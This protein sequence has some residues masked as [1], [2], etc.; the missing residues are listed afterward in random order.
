MNPKM[1]V[2]NANIPALIKGEDL[3]KLKPKG[4]GIDYCGVYAFCPSCS[5]YVMTECNPQNDC[6]C[7]PKTTRALAGI[8]TATDSMREDLKALAEEMGNTAHAFNE[9][10]AEFIS[11]ANIQ[12]LEDFTDWIEAS[13]RKFKLFDT[14]HEGSEMF[15][16][17]VRQLTDDFNALV[18]AGSQFGYMGQGFV[19]FTKKL[20]DSGIAIKEI[21]KFIN[22][23]L[24]TG[25]QGLNDW[26]QVGMQ[27]QED[28]NENWAI[29][30]G[31]FNAMIA[32][33][34]NFIDVLGQMGTSFSELRQAAEAAGFE[35]SDAFLG[36]EE[37]QKR[38]ADNQI[39]VNGIKGLDAALLGLANTGM[40]TQNAFQ[41]FQNQAK[42]ALDSL[43][44][45]GFSAEQA[46]S[47]L[48][49]M[50]SDLRDI[51]ADSAVELD[52]GTQ[53][54]IDQA[55]AAGALDDTLD[56]METMVGLMQQ[57][58][59]ILA[60]Q[61]PEAARQA[62]QALD[63]E[64]GGAIR[65]L[66]RLPIIDTGGRDGINPGQGFASGVDFV[67]PPGFSNDS[68]PMRASSGERVLIEPQG[69]TQ[70]GST[71]INITMPGMADMITMNQFLHD[72]KNDNFVIE[73]IKDAVQ[74]AD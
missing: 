13:A 15:N 52:A 23:Q 20:K 11:Q 61:F 7:Q 19:D 12:T 14:L 67:V 2:T 59:D 69:Q 25:L 35:M 24:N 39:L 40:L 6:V 36:L 71:T 68:F 5:N 8:S 58:V 31:Y 41:A 3:E 18:N 16:D 38:I 55:D 21:S 74:R 73:T 28:W 37:L 65:N 42:K 10:T 57:L 47:I 46:L 50:L 49:P 62:G 1:E 4:L 33:G 56:P 72:I 22:D 9:L 53:A 60:N 70:T 45:A 64:V 34:A 51:A 66:P 44:L 63:D 30:L 27:S 17:T 43:M 26:L 54:L 48:G 32:N 29:T